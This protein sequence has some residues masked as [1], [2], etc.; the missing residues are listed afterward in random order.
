MRLS[1]LI[2]LLFCC[3]PIVVAQEVRRPLSPDQPTLPKQETQAEEASDEVD[4]AVY[5][6][7]GLAEKIL[8]LKSVKTKTIGI[9]RLANLLWKD[10]EVYSRSLFEKA[11]TMTTGDGIDS[12]LQASLRRSIIALIARRDPAWANRLIEAATQKVN[13]E[14]DGKARSDLNLSTAETLLDGDSDGAVK[15]A[16]RSLQG[17]VNP[18][19][20]LDFLLSLRKRNE[21]S[22]NQLFLQTLTHLAQQSTVD[23]KGFHTI[24]VYLFTAPDM[25]D[26]ERYAITLVD[27][28]LVPN[29]T[30]QR[31]GVPM[32]LVRAYLGVA[33]KV[34]W[35]AVSDPQQRQVS[36]ALGRLLLPKAISAAPDLAA[37]I[38]A[39]MSAISSG[40]PPSLAKD[41]AYKYMDM[42]PPS[43]EESLSNAENKPDQL[44]R[45]IAYLDLA[46]QAWLKGDFKTA[47]IASGRISDQEANNRM[48]VLNNFG[49][50]A[51]QLKQD[52]KQFMGA[53]RLANK[54]PQ[55]IERAILFLAVA[56]AK[57]KYGDASE[58]EEAIGH[59]LRGARSVSDSRRPFLFLI[60]AAQLADLH[61]PNLPSVLAETAKN[62]N[63]FNEA[64]FAGLD[65]SQDVQVGP[66]TERFPLTFAPIQF[67]FGPAF[68]IV[69]KADLE[70]A[71]VTIDELKNEDLRAR[72]F[73]EI[74][75]VLLERP[76]KKVPT[77]PSSKRA[78]GLSLH[79][80]RCFN[81]SFTLS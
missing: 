6:V 63:S 2:P 51:W 4:T 35:R 67:E 20:L 17:D 9:A 38:E 60:A 25:L 5:L 22:A 30:T 71:R 12:K 36:Y 45:D 57:A 8:A 13:S 41:S 61:S 34:L 46:F 48:S 27:N 55:G 39:A 19:F 18:T 49:E 54:L 1:F 76:P 21:T 29:I 59:A 14:I 40:I 15:F 42:V 23:V 28:M 58:A 11:L 31:P 50:A 7:H 68:R 16:E 53:E 62:F 65:W 77:K 56:E 37:P 3:C 75:G 26:S 72:G 43:A 73:V 79:W 52:G 70:A 64:S 44:S 10:D 24:G 74:A 69:S 32:S 66:L 47:R 81:S 80:L 78:G 33:G